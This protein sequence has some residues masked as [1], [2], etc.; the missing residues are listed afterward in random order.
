MCFSNAAARKERPQKGQGISGLVGDSNL[1]APGPGLVQLP[2]T[3]SVLAPSLALA[4][5]LCEP[6]KIWLPLDAVPEPVLFS[7]IFELDLLDIDAFG[8]VLADEL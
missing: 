1:A 6:V 3:S 8:I 4:C 2:Q 5:V 7:D